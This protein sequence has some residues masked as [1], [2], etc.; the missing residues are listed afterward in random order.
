MPKVE[1]KNYFRRLKSW[2]HSEEND[3]KKFNSRRFIMNILYLTIAFLFT[4]FIYK[5]I[6]FFNEYNLLFLRIGSVLLL[7]G[8]YFCIKQVFYILKELQ[9]QHYYLPYG[10]KI[11]IA[12]LV[13][14]L[15][16]IIYKNPNIFTASIK[17][18]TDKIVI[19]NFNPFSTS[20]LINAT[21][22]VSPSAKSSR[23]DLRNFINFLP[24]P[25][26]FLIF[27]AL[28]IGILMTL[29]SKFI[30]HKSLP[31]WLVWSL[32][33]LGVIMAFQY[34]IPYERVGVSDVG[35]CDNSN[36]FKLE[37]NFFGLGQ[38]SLS[39][40]CPDYMSSQCRPMCMNN[41]PICQCEANIIDIIFHQ[42]GDWILN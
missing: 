17:K 9:R 10:Y 3:Y 38:L 39:L 33:I 22:I 31:E 12:V 30:F 29:L 27:W 14:I 2:F 7:I 26:G 16:L 4:L 19:S 24:L 36:N 40:T 18:I 23:F 6:G 35:S 1:T 11:L 41:K 5:T 32:I 42:K 20:Q 15:L 21:N 28:I 25:W 37:N 34:K 8:T 13:I